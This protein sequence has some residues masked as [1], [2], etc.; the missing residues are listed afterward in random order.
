[1]EA[2]ILG[3]VLNRLRASEL[4]HYGYHH[5]YEQHQQDDNLQVNAAI[6]REGPRSMPISPADVFDHQS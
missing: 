6:K 1:V 3:L 2:S 4:G 5:Y